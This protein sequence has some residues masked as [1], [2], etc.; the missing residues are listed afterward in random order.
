MPRLQLKSADEYVAIAVKRLQHP[1]RE[2]WTGVALMLIGAIGFV[3]FVIVALL[4]R[5][6]GFSF[7]G[8]FFSLALAAG[9]AWMLVRD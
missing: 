1:T 3:V 6:W 2:T 5:S 9:G 4:S 7:W 8:V